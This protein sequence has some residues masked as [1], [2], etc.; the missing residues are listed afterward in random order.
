[1]AVFDESRAQNKTQTTR[2][3]CNLTI[4]GFKNPNIIHKIGKRFGTNAVGFQGINCPFYVFFNQK[5]II[6]IIL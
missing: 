6:Q 2:C 4:N 1:L 3:L 5:K